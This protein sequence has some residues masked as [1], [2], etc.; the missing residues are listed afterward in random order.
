MKNSTFISFA[1]GL[2]LL[3]IMVSWPTI[4]AVTYQSHDYTLSKNEIRNEAVDQYL[5]RLAWSFECV[6]AC[7]KAQVAHQD[8]KII[9]SNGAYSYGC[10]QFQ[11]ATYL[12]FA[13]RY[14]IDPWAN[15]GIYNCDNQWKVARAMFLDDKEMAAGH[16]ATSIYKRGLGLPK[17]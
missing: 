16:W 1:V 4:D 15:G 9:D 8:F 17:I 7:Q 3:I 14:K 12:S 5:S 10:L 2:G 11:Q 13:K 6:G